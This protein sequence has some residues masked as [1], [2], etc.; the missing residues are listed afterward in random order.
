MHGGAMVHAGLVHVQHGMQASVW[1]CSPEQWLVCSAPRS[2]HAA[3]TGGQEAADPPC[4][5]CAALP[6]QAAELAVEVVLPA[7]IL[8]LGLLFSVAALS[9]GTLAPPLQCGQAGGEVEAATAE[10]EAQ[11]LGGL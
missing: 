10:G 11:G 1:R 5:L 8:L 4:L 2:R 3:P 9:T 7:A 6:P